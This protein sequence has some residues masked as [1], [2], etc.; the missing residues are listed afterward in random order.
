LLREEGSSSC[1]KKASGVMDLHGTDSHCPEEKEMLTLQHITS[2]TNFESS[3]V[4]WQLAH[5]ERVNKKEK[6]KSAYIV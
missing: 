4:A 1:D 3:S 2:G 5:T 6:C